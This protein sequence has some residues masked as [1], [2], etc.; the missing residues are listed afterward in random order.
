MIYTDDSAMVRS[1]E[2]SFQT[3]FF[4]AEALKRFTPR[5]LSEKRALPKRSGKLFYQ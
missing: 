2:R 1:G 3:F 5:S 4:V